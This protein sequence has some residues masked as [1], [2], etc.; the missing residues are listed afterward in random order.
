MRRGLCRDDG[1]ELVMD[2]RGDEPPYADAAWDDDIDFEALDCVE[3]DCEEIVLS[4]EE[5]DGLT[6]ESWNV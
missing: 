2:P 6:E 3:I 5:W 1:A 4:D